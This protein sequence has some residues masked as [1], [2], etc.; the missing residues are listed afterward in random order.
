MSQLPGVNRFLDVDAVCK[1][2][3]S[4]ANQLFDPELLRPLLDDLRAR[5]P[6][7]R[8]MEGGAQLQYLLDQVRVVDG[9]YFN[10]A[11]DV[12]W[13]MKGANQHSAGRRTVRLN[14]Q[15]CLRTGVPTGVS[16]NGQDGI[17]EGSAAIGFIEPG[18]IHLFD[19]G[20]VSFPYLKAILDSQAHLLCNLAT[21]V[22]FTA[23]RELP[24]SAADRQAGVVSDRVGRLTGSDTRTAPDAVLREVVVRFIDRDGKPRTLR[25]LTDLLCLPARLV[26]ELYRYRWQVEIFFRWLKVHASFEH[27]VSHSR[28]GITLGFYVAVIAAM[29]M[30][31][32][33]QRNLSKYGYNLMSMV[34]AGLGDVDDIL[35]LLEHRERERQRDRERQ[36]RKRAAKKPG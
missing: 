24:L 9:S 30:C 36:A 16:L 31:L 28:R 1:S 27:L 25:L 20:V 32:Q 34:A 12:L 5:L 7:L 29:L 14:C 21:T 26:A 23:E 11:A 13:A 4:D 19:S 22:R 35:P 33:T 15:L 6:N 18:A 2:T 17:G 10:V 3:L 8:Q